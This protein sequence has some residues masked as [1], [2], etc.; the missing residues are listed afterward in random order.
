MPA[1]ECP[2]RLPIDENEVPV[3][4]QKKERVADA[5]KRGRQPARQC[6]LAQ[7]R[8]LLQVDVLNSALHLA[9][10]A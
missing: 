9:D 3:V 1:T 4:V 10:S 6:A 5:F 8:L 2:N 7:F